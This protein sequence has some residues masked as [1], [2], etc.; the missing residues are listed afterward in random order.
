MSGAPIPAIGVADAECQNPVTGEG[1]DRLS[2]YRLFT[3]AEWAQ[4]RADT[5]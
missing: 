3:R 2:P 4:L 5:P 1:P